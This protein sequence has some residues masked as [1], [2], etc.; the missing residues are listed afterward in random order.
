MS[1]N[2]IELLWDSLKSQHESVKENKKQSKYKVLRESQKSINKKSENEVSESAH[3]DAIK[4]ILKNLEQF[5]QDFEIKI[6]MPSRKMTVNPDASAHKLND[7]SNPHLMAVY[8][9]EEAIHYLEE[10]LNT[11]LSDPFLDEDN[12]TGAQAPMAEIP[13]IPDTGSEDAPVDSLEETMEEDEEFP[14][15]EEQIIDEWVFIEED[16]DYNG[17]ATLLYDKD[18]FV[19]FIQKDADTSNPKRYLAMASS[20]DDIESDVVEMDAATLEELCSW[21]EMNGFAFPTDEVKDL[22]KDEEELNESMKLAKDDPAI[23][24]VAKEVEK[25]KVGSAEATSIDKEN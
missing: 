2:Y 7:K 8:R 1:R 15:Q 6:L 20:S 23:S 16:P 10:Q 21:L 9:L 25:A 5:K 11:Q 3:S 14:E 19:T 12:E 4:E 18:S 17:N 24:T 13:Q 22:M